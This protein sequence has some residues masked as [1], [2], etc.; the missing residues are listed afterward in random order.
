MRYWDSP[1]SAAN[2][3]YFRA[4]LD[5]SEA[6]DSEDLKKFVEH[7]CKRRDQMVIIEMVCTDRNGHRLASE[8]VQGPTFSTTRT[9]RE[10][11]TNRW[12]SE[13]SDSN[14]LAPYIFSTTR[15]A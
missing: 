3:E 5:K 14:G 15:S 9:D 6:A 8:V 4:L 2:A 12:V 11:L 13:Y 10:A 1:E 7:L